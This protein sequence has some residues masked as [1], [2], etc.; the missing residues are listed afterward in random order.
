MPVIY[1]RDPERSR[2]GGLLDSARAS[3]SAVLILLGETGVGKS[4]LLD[5]AREQA[6]GM[7]VLTGNGVESEAQLPFAALHQVVR[8]VLGLV[9]NLPQPQAAALRGPLAARSACRAVVVSRASAT[10]VFQAVTR[11]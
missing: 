9:D 10:L 7:R 4:A 5:D 1:G 6:E 8:P 11:G 3:R 2:I